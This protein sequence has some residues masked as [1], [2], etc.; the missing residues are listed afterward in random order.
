M[1]Q[2]KTIHSVYFSPTGNSRIA[3]R[4]VAYALKRELGAEYNELDLTPAAARRT[5][6]TFD[7]DDIVVIAMPVYAGRLPNKIA[8]DIAANISGFGKTRLIALCTYGKRSPG[9]ALRE[10]LIL[11]RQNGFVPLAAR[12]LEC[13]HA[14]SAKIARGRPNGTDLA[15]LDELG[16]GLARSIAAGQDRPLDFDYESPLAPY[17][18]PLKEDSTPARFLKAKPVVDLSLCTRCAK[19]AAV[20]PMDSIK[21]DNP[22]KTDGVCIKCQACIKVCPAGARRF[23]DADFISHV[24]M[25]E[26]SFG[27]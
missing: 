10:L 2:I 3:A 21:A 15:E 27:E 22:E 4:A 26:K 11:G 12:S 20:C 23:E 24:R 6:H 13:E 5:K 16:A 18:T 7:N 9:D 17:Y 14:F 8:P 19:C 25:L 1:S